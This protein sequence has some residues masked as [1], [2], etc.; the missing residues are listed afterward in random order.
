MSG[1]QGFEPFNTDDWSQKHPMM[2]EQNTTYQPTYRT[3]NENFI[4]DALDDLD[5]GLNYAKEVLQDHDTKLGRT[6]RKHSIWAK[7]I[8]KDIEF[9]EK[10]I[11]EIKG[12][13]GYGTNL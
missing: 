10:T 2:T 4:D 5:I 7:Q 8:E 3:I 11:K 13:C 1:G 9:I 12:V 6:T